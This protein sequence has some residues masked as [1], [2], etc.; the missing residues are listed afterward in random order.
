MAQVAIVYVGKKARKD[1]NVANTGTVWNGPGDV[2][3]VDA[4]VAAKLLS[5]VDI[6]ARA[7]GETEKVPDAEVE[8]TLT[9][10]EEEEGEELQDTPT[11][12]NIDDA[13]KDQLVEYAMREFG[14]DLD[15]RKNIDSLRDLVRT[16]TITRNKQG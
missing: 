14:V 10:P 2:Q 12:F 16:E 11:A 9:K 1:D 4:S 13:N 15:K 7:E 5:H 3:R 6:W 8:S